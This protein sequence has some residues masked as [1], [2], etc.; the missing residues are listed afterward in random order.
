LEDSLIEACKKFPYN[1]FYMVERTSTGVSGLDEALDGGFPKDSVTLIT[2]GPG[3]GKTTFCT[4]FLY[5]GLENEE[6]CLYLTTGQSPEELRRDAK[7][8]GIDFDN[9][10]H[11]LTMAHVNPSKEVEGMI[12]D[13]IKNEDFD[14][15]VLDSLS[16]FEMYWGNRDGLRQYLNRLI[17]RLKEM[18]V[19][20]V[21]TSER[22]EN[23]SGNLTRFGVAEFVVDGVIS[24]Q[25]YA[26]GQSQF[27]SLQIIKMRRTKID[28]EILD[29]EINE[30]GF[31]VSKGEKFA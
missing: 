28:G 20:A 13:H 4:Q 11:N 14:R 2:G 17:E 12:A 6:K 18:D 10:I 8:F 1:L 22:P 15:I 16:V 19:T 31:S 24:L 5:E 30:E 9:Y 27:R 7:E 23:Q 25:G 29:I 3:S 26:L 21:V